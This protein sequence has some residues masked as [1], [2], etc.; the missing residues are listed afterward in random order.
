MS[1]RNTRLTEEI[2]EAFRYLKYCLKFVCHSLLHLF[3]YLYSFLL[4]QTF[5]PFRVRDSGSRLY[6]LIYLIT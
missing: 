1:D 4:S 3:R 2:F 5:G 6:F